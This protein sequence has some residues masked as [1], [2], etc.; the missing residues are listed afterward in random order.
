M[1]NSPNLKELVARFLDYLSTQKQYSSLTLKAYA[2]VLS[3][4]T[5]YHGEEL[6]AESLNKDALRA[7]IWELKRTGHG[8]A[9]LSQSVA[10]LKSF[11]KFLM[12]SLIVPVNPAIRLQMPK[13]PQRLVSFLS[14][15]E[16]QPSQVDGAVEDQTLQRSQVLLELIYGS[17]LRISEC[18][19]LRWNQLDWSQGTVRVR[20]KGNKE[21]IVPITQRC[22][23]YLQKYRVG[24][25][26]VFANAQGEPLNVRTLRRDIHRL[27]RW[28]GW[29]GK[30]S[31]H[32][33]RH[34]FA[35]HLLDNGADLVAVQEM[36]GHSSL[37]TTQVYTHVSAQRLRASYLQAHPRGH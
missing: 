27:L 4:F 29:E 8:V 13:K 30:A 22:A 19:G 2:H 24:G 3:E 15:N 21:R 9:T 28:M 6:G 32:V 7:W 20:G 26:F 34:S 10:C 1:T 35:T 17:G 23:E 14:E 11:G 5:Q 16:L 31:P 33:L 12:R 37:S 36:L 25:A 18:A